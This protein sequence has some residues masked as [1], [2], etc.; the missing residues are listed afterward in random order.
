[1]KLLEILKHPD[2]RL[3]IVAAEVKNFDSSVE[4]IISNMF[5]TMYHSGGVG[6]AATQVDHHQRI[7]VIDI[8]PTKNKPITLINPKIIASSGTQSYKEGCLSVP[9]VR[10]DTDRLGDI[11]VEAQDKTGKTF[12]VKAS[13]LLSVCIQHE[14]DHLD[15]KIFIDKINL[16]KDKNW[17]S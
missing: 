9:G 6:L 8:S 1:M 17:W 2:E 3:R 5:Y 14:I 10:K 15:G 12:I 16:K 4:E 7:V 13:G 11:A